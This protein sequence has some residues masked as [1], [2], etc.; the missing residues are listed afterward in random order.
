M[1]TLQ[2]A[3]TIVSTISSIVINIV[4]NDLD[5]KKRNIIDNLKF[6][7]FKKHNKKRLEEFKH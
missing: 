2:I 4:S 3:N 7:K 5:S 6:K 1:D